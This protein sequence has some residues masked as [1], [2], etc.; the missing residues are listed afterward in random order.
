MHTDIPFHP[1]Q[2]PLIAGK[3]S[4]LHL[5]EVFAGCVDF[6]ES[7]LFLGGQEDCPLTMLYLN[8]M[9]RT[10]R[11][12]DYILKPLAQ[13]PAL[14]SLPP[15]KIMELLAKGTLYTMSVKP[16]SSMDEA[17]D[18]LVVGSVLLVFPEEAQMLSCIV[19]TEEKRSISPPENEPVLKG[20]RDCFVESLRT[21][22]SLVRRRLRTPYLRIHEE[23]VGRQSRLPLDILSIEGL[24]QPE[25]I[26]EAKKRIQSMD[27]DTLIQASMLEESLQDTVKTPFPLLMYTERPDRFCEALADGQVGILVEGLPFG[28]LL[29]STLGFF[30]RANEDHSKN[31]LE[32]SCLRILRYLSLVLALFLPAFYLAVVNFHPEMLPLSL[33]FGIAKAK[34]L[35]PFSSLFEVLLLLL[36]FEL[37]Q[38]AGL[39]L[40]PAIGTTLSI[41]G[42]LV[43]GTAAVQANFISPAVLIVVATS[44]IASYTASSP[45]F[46][47]A[48]R[49][50]RFVFVL[51]AGVWGLYG[52]AGLALCLL[53]HLSSLTSFGVPYLSNLTQAEPHGDETLLRKPLIWVKFRDFSLKPCNRRKVK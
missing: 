32:V 42:G 51:G 8:G 20:A 53:H 13:N 1:R 15:S 38:E 40:P 17:V 27:V 18:A 50:W 23:I 36:A 33:A 21:N 48:V 41:L 6:L 19:P 25:F 30:F 46:L 47:G 45:D 12:N 3:L 16:I 11:A 34:A 29:P 35:V 10:E 43:V 52:V 5:R 37:L 26:L 49:I 28:Y 31:W 2:T 9:V 22:T 14:A 44:G 7:P 4:L 24:T 39:R